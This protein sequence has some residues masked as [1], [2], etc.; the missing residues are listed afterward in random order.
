MEINENHEKKASKESGRMLQRFK[1]TDRAESQEE[2]N[3]P[4]DQPHGRKGKYLGDQLQGKIGESMMMSIAE[5]DMGLRQEFSFDQTRRGF[6]GVYRDKNNQLIIA[7]SKGTETNG[8]YH[9]GKKQL[10]DEGLREIAVKMKTKGGEYYTIGNAKLG[11]EILRKGPENVKKYLFWL[12]PS[13]LMM[14]VSE[15]NSNGSWEPV[16]NFDVTDR[17]GPYLK[18]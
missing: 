2:K 4:K 16:Q 17:D 9:L 3:E 18:Y 13:S 11:E 7:E 12:D 5:N 1:P 14:T 15:R 10:T 6:D 8:R